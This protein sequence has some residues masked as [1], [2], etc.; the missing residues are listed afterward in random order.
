MPKSILINFDSSPLTWGFSSTRIF[1]M[2]YCS[3]PSEFN[4]DFRMKD[5][6]ARGFGEAPSSDNRY[7]RH[8]DKGESARLCCDIILYDM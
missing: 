2:K 4:S 1:C 7:H 6:E 3:I 8:R 5:H